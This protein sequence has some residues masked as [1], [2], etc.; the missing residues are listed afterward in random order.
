MHFIFLQSS[1]GVQGTKEIGNVEEPLLLR[2]SHPGRKQVCDFIRILLM[3]S[4]IN[5]SAK[6]GVHPL[7]Q[8]LEVSKNV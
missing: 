4:L 1:T 7:I 5:I 3:D 2:P 6:D 8:L